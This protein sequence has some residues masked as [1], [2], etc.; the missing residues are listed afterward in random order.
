MASAIAVKNLR[1]YWI[2]SSD[3]KLPTRQLCDS[4]WMRP[5]ALII[6]TMQI[7]LAVW[8]ALTKMELRQTV[9][10]CG[11]DFIV[12]LVC[13]QSKAANPVPVYALWAAC[14]TILLGFMM[15]TIKSHAIGSAHSEFT[16]M[17]V[18]SFFLLFATLGF[19]ILPHSSMDI[20][21]NLTVECAL[22]WMCTSAPVV[23]YLVPI[24]KLLYEEATYDYT[25]LQQAFQCLSSQSRAS[26]SSVISLN[27][28]SQPISIIQLHQVLPAL[29]TEQN[30]K[31]VASPGKNQSLMYLNTTESTLVSAKTLPTATTQASNKSTSAVSILKS[32]EMKRESSMKL[33]YGKLQRIYSYEVVYRVHGSIY[34]WKRGIITAFST[35]MRKV[36]QI[37]PL[38][39]D[40]AGSSFAASFDA[41]ELLKSSHVLTHP[42]VTETL[43]VSVGCLN[44]CKLNI[45]FFNVSEG[46]E[47]IAMIE[48]L[49]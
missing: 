11:T 41:T 12:E 10:A 36:V 47:F 19:S 26:T 32:S 35:G 48:K 13:A 14:I 8:C 16:L 23:M 15:I 2:Y 17:L 4:F 21:S 7:L 45:D 3:Q 24:C 9:K 39:H 44:G 29:K 46:K 34:A 37:I 28:I 43:R 30:S 42:F 1:L 20:V 49:K 18:T 22:V 6:I 33:K 5:V 38:R 31:V 25:L 40:I 27:R